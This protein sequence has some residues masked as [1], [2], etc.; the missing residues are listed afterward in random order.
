MPV[1]PLWQLADSENLVLNLGDANGR[2]LLVVV[3]SVAIDSSENVEAVFAA[4]DGGAALSRNHRDQTSSRLFEFDLFKQVAPIGHVVL[5]SEHV[6]DV[7]RVV[8]QAQ[9]LLF[10]FSFEVPL[11]GPVEV[12]FV[13]EEAVA[14]VHL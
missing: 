2:N 13:F 1:L 10:Y 12:Q 14:V 7:G 9:H 5:H 11:L 4:I 3:E 8:V 6:V